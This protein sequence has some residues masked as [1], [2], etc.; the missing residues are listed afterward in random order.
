MKIKRISRSKKRT[1]GRPSTASGTGSA[2]RI[3]DSQITVANQSCIN[4]ITAS[5]ELK[6]RNDTSYASQNS[7]IPSREI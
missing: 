5:T 3:S 2:I 4:N 7:N 6:K 1:Q